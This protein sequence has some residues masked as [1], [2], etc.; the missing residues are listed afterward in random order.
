MVA[1]LANVS[2]ELK[3]IAKELAKETAIAAKQFYWTEEYT[4]LMFRQ[5]VSVCNR[6]MNIYCKLTVTSTIA[7][8]LFV[9]IFLFLAI[10]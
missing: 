6:L 1:K 3:E 9:D 10:L 7:Q 2:I 5:S 4:R 8:V